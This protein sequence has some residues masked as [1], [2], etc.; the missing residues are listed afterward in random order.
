MD[1]KRLL[2][3]NN[4][5]VSF[6]TDKGKVEVVNNASFFVKAGQ[7]V[8]L[9]GESGCG[10]TVT[11]SS[12]IRLLPHP[13][14]EIT[15]GAVLFEGVNL[16]DLPVEAMYK[17]RGGKIGMIFQEPMTAMNPVQMAGKQ[18]KEV[19][20][21]HRPDLTGEDLAE[22]IQKLLKLVEMPSPKMRVKNYPFQL[23]GGMRQR[24]MIAMALA[25]Q[26][27]ILIADEPTTALDVTV[28]AQIL[29]LI[30]EL[31]KSNAMGVIFITHDMGV[32]AEVSDDIVVMYAG[33]IVETGPVRDIFY[34]P[35]H[36]YTRGLI[37]S[38]PHLETEPKT[39][40]PTIRGNVPAPSAYPETCRFANRCDFAMD[41]C[42]LH[43]PEL[44]D[45]TE[46]HQV[47]CFRKGEIYG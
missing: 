42:R 31:Q 1:E 18:I 26:P 22:E 2:T 17:V 11:A 20:Q 36:P 23:S 32:V 30:K 27:K 39:N 19:L 43:T 4:L 14:G 45:F 29:H 24:M 46:G 44:E 34:S 47:R 3:I 12:I 9:V 33:Q 8:A 25:A 40:L 13:H 16:L 7:T 37:S 41:H 10:K 28:Q 35:Q 21:L 6:H 38:M 5:S 15:S